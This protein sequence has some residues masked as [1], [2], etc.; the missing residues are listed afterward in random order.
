M[1][2][3][4]IEIV[5]IASESMGV[6]SFC[7]RIGTPDLSILLDPSAALSKRYRLEPHPQEYR[8]LE[9]KLQQIFVE[10]RR[11]DLISISH[12]HF[13]HV[14]P[15]F[16]DF[17]YIF[18][19]REE[20]QRMLE[21]KEIWAKDSRENINPSQRRRAYYFQ[22][23]IEGIVRK[24]KW[25]D[26]EKTKYDNTSIEFSQPLPHGPERTPLG[27]VIATTIKYDDHSVVFAPDIQGP[28]SESTLQYLQSQK[29]S[30][31]IVGG[32]PT[33]ISRFRDHHRAL[34]K[35]AL[36]TLAKSVSVV[37]VDHHLLRDNE[38]RDWLV[39]IR[40]AAEI[41]GNTVYTMA[42]VLGEKN[43]SF[44]AER[45]QLY[46]TIPPNDDFMNWCNATDEYKKANRPP[47]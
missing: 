43:R 42:E 12:Y 33:Y 9:S 18:S 41:E 38:W 7:T 44:E 27:F 37:I 46:E 15:G 2:I 29:P 34:A 26:S 10:A 3:G 24:L 4:D 20:L 11:A 19:S 47:I 5:P 32:P 13:D 31:V 21:G 22:K 23:D 1:N 17:H 39:P 30:A 16:T 8:M 25:S 35:S 40:E 45:I 14:R 36:R 6:R 28:C